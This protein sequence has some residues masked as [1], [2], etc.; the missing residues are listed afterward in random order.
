MKTYLTTL[1]CASVLALSIAGCAAEEP[2]SGSAVDTA[3]LAIAEAGPYTL[4]GSNYSLR[5]CSIISKLAAEL[6][7]Q[8]DPIIYSEDIRAV[9]YD[10]LTA[11]LSSMLAAGTSDRYA[12]LNDSL[13]RV[14]EAFI[15][16][17]IELGIS[18]LGA[19]L[20]ECSAI[21]VVDNEELN[22]RGIVIAP[23]AIPNLTEE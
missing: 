5:A 4:E 22:E 15:N 17:E 20:S 14:D 8:S 11:Q 23:G 16:D 1:A 19:V 7:Y 12:A 9:T 13:I 6:E 10:V 18:L 2:E 21:T 3:S